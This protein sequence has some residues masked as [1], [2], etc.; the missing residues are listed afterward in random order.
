M[1]EVKKM[2]KSAMFASTVRSLL[3]VVA[4]MI[5]KR[6]YDVSGYIE[7]IVSLVIVVGV[8]VWSDYSHKHSKKV[9]KVECKK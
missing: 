2:L 6:G 3:S 1:N 5:A 9:I 8:A 7:P 4:G